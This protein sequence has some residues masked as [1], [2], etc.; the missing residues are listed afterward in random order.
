MGSWVIRVEVLVLLKYIGGDVVR[1]K[2]KG[3]FLIF[4]GIKE[5]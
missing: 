4:L 3:N 5:G 2:F 1:N